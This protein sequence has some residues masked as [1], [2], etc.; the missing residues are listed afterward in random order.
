MLLTHL[1][2]KPVIKKPLIIFSALIA[3]VITTAG[4]LLLLYLG[5]I[6]SRACID[7]EKTDIRSL[8]DNGY[9]SSS[10][11]AARFKFLEAT[12]KKGGNI[13]SYEHP[14]TGPNGERLYIDL[15]FF[16]SPDNTD[17][18]VVSSGTHGVEGFAGSGIQT[19]L[20][21]EGI[22]TNLPHNL[23]LIMIH[24]LNPY[25][26]AHIRRFTEDNVDL[27]RNFADHSTQHPENREYEELA[28]VIAPASITFWSEVKSWGYL[29]WYRFT[30][31]KTAVQSAISKG[32]YSHPTGLFYGGRSNTWSNNTLRSIVHDYLQNKKRVVL[33]DLH[34]G[35]G[36]YG[37]AEVILNVPENSPEYRRANNIWGQGFV[38]TTVTGQSVSVHIA[39]SIKNAFSKMMHNSEVTAVSLEFGTYPPMEVFKALRAENW[40]H[41]H[42]DPKHPKAKQI[43]TCLLSA[44]YPDD[45]NWNTMVWKKGKDVVERAITF[46]GSNESIP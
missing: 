26:M 44:F 46:L 33:I 45:E 3:V 30:K 11:K 40:L 43:K 20:L 34:T 8:D 16:G 35:L 10:Y 25:G 15:A 32:Q 14:E 17:A 29:L 31:G 2:S 28:N 9:F 4:I 1:G 13:Q 42:A 18:L 41:H 24:A 19:G 6:T 27:N 23:N 38:R 21:S 39:N 37:H 5:T 22:T 7:V 36:E 12:R